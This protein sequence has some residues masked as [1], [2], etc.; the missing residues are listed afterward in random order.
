M[1]C[2][3]LVLEWFDRFCLSDCCDVLIEYAGYL[4][5]PESFRFPYLVSTYNEIIKK[6]GI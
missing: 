4:F 6:G 1:L 2:N 3:I 5:I